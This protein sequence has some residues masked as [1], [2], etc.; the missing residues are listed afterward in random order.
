MIRWRLYRATSSRVSSAAGVTSGG[1][2]VDT[3]TLLDSKSG[4]L[5]IS[6]VTQH[7]GNDRRDLPEPRCGTRPQAYGMGY[8]HGLGLQVLPSALTHSGSK[9]ELSLSLVENVC[10]I[11]TGASCPFS[12]HGS[13]RW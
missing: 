11:I 5:S 13:W 8:G 7:N 1:N 10:C 6:A 9:R 12:A 3:D 2:G 4:L